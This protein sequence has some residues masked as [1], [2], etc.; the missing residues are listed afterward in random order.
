[1]TIYLTSNNAFDTNTFFKKNLQLIISFTNIK[2]YA[3]IKKRCIL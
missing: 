2:V 1:M 3:T